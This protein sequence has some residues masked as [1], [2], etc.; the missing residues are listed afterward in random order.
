MPSF[1][2]LSSFSIYSSF[3]D[4]KNIKKAEATLESLNE[5]MNS[6]KINGKSSFPLLEP[7]DWKIISYTQGDKPKS[8][9]K[10]C[11]CLCDDTSFARNTPAIGSM[12]TDSQL[13]KCNKLGVCKNFDNGLNEFNIKLRDEVEIDFNNGNFIINGKNIQ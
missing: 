7:K 8:C 3:I 11:I 5:K 1:A 4:E 13:E 2:C 10:N 9:I 12:I 6:V